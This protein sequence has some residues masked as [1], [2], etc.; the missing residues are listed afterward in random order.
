MNFDFINYS[1]GMLLL[2]VTI[3]NLVGWAVIAAVLWVLCEFIN[4]VMA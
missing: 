1:R 4:W 2:F 3:A